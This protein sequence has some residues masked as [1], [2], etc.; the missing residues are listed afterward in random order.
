VWL[1]GLTGVPEQPFWRTAKLSRPAEDVA[2]LTRG[3]LPDG[4]AQRIRYGERG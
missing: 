4:I 2:L 3:W 1:A